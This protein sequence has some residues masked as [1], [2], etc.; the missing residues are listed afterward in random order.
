MGWAN[1][2][3]GWATGNGAEVDAGNNLAIST[4]QVNQRLGG[5]TPAPNYVGGIRIFGENDAGSVTGIPYLKSPM[6]SEDFR[7]SV[8]I[9]TTQFL[10]NFTATSQNTG[11]WKHAFTTMTMTQSAGFLNINPAL[12]TVSGNYA[13]LQT[14]KFFT[15]QGDA[16]NHNEVV[17]QFTSNF[18]ANQV[19]EF[20]HF[21]GTAGAVPADGAFW[22]MTSAGLQGVI[23]YSGVETTTGVLLASVSLNTNYKFKMLVS[24]REVSFW[25]NDV[26]YAELITPAANAIPFLWLNLPLCFLMRNTGTVTGGITV[27]VGTGHLT[28]VDLHTSKPW[29]EQMA[30][31]GLAYQGQDGDTMGSLAIYSNAA[32]AAAAAL[33]NTTAAAGNTGLGGAV[34]VLP[35]LTSGTDGILFS[36]LNPI[37]TAI[38]PGKT[39]VVKGIIIDASIQVILAG[40]PLVYAMGIAYGHTAVSLATTESASFATGT[41]KAPRRIAIG[42]FAFVVTAAAGVSAQNIKMVFSSPITVNPGEYFQFTARNVGTVTTSGAV[43]FTAT[44]DYYFE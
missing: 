8:G 38:Q 24:Q 41:T 11:R 9:D 37:A 16:E 26:L 27:R 5:E 7:M 36:Y 31:Q 28:L 23:S 32:L 21:L 39:L 20:G 19:Y 40:G 44:P 25:I 13:Y 30:T 10:Y 12:A 42:Q 35:T 14:W 4:R 34:L 1:K 29:A 18:P 43:L 17:Q 3:I 15:L 2:I 6:V 22:R 33:T